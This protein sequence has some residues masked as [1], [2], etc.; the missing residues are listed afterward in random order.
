MTKF[1]FLA[2]SIVLSAGAFAQERQYEFFIVGNTNL[3]FPG[4]GS[5]KG[6]YPILWYDK[7]TKPKI[8]IGGFGVGVSVFRAITEKVGVK[9]Q[10]NVSKNA[11]WDE[12]MELR[13]YNNEPL[14]HFQYGS[15]DFS[16]GIGGIL[17]YFLSRKMSVGTG[18]GARL[19]TITLSRMPVFENFEL[20]ADDFAVNRYNKTILPVIPVEWSLK[21][22]KLLFNIRYEYGLSNRYKAD[23][24]EYKKERFGVLYF[25]VGWRIR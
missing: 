12:A 11:Y 21:G 13:G 3:Y 10:A 9:G 8:L 19:F 6:I 16:V 17:H 22:E 18:L 1:F 24:A 2:G 14:G 4:N 15:S 20:V 23:L 7:T 25:E 5:G